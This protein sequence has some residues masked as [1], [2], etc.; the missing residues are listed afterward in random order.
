[1]IFNGVEITQES[2][3]ATR[4]HFADISQRRIDEALDGTSPPA[5]HV[6]IGD[7][8]IMLEQQKAADLAGANDHTFTFVQ[9]AYWIQTGECVALLF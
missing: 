3:I 8:V 7:Y 4:Q 2:V 5:S 1:M 9:R 6:N